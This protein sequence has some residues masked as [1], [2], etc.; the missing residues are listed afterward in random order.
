MGVPFG[1]GGVRV[2]CCMW[3]LRVLRQAKRLWSVCFPMVGSGCQGCLVRVV[4]WSFRAVVAR[5]CIVMGLRR[6]VPAMA[7]MQWSAA[8]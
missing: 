1:V 4:R 2:W 8:W 3:K 6:L 5:V 7:L